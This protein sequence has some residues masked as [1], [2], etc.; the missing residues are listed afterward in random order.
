MVHIPHAPHQIFFE[1]LGNRARW[2]IVH[3]LGRKGTVSA[4]RIAAALKLEQSLASHHLRRLEV[5]GFVKAVRKGKERRYA[6]NR[7]TV[8]PLLAL[9][10]RHISKFCTRC[11]ACV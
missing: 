7:V 10:D 3:F 6:L 1:T 2:D 11:K 8:G 4:S 5:C 9:M